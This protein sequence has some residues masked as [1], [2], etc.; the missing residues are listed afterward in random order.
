[1]EDKQPLDPIEDEMVVV[2]IAEEQVDEEE[3]L[4]MP[5]G[6]LGISF[7]STLTSYAVYLGVTMLILMIIRIF[8][9]GW[10]HP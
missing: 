9:P 5:F 7:L 4:P 2:D 10:M 3:P 6:V 1:M 8:M